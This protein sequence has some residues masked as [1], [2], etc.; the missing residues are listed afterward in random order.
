MSKLV[1]I[2]LA[3]AV[4]VG[5]A[6]CVAQEHRATERAQAFCAAALPGADAASLQAQ[7]LAQGAH[8]GQTRW[9]P[10]ADGGEQLWATFTGVFPLSRHICLVTARAGQ[11]VEA[12]LTYLD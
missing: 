11:V 7:A 12:R 6:W 9:S 10:Q 3:A 2:V 8:A 4:P 5:L 1:S